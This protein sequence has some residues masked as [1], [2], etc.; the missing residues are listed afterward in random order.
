VADTVGQ[1]A[2]LRFAVERLLL[3]G[4]V[5]WLLDSLDQTDPAPEGDVMQALGRLVQGRWKRC[6]VWVSGRPYAFRIA[7]TALEPIDPEHPWQFLRIGQLDEPE[8]RQ[9]LERTRPP[10]A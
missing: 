8:C 6:R 3:E 10:G 7:R 2:A 4:R 1:S 9:L 5:T